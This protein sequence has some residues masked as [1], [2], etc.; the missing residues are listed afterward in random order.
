VYNFQLI[1]EVSIYC[2]YLWAGSTYYPIL[3]K[4]SINTIIDY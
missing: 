3:F 2:T 1:S 4:M